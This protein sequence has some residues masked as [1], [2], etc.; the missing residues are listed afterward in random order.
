MNISLIGVF[1]AFFT[2]FLGFLLEGL[3]FSL[4][5]Q[6]TAMLIV[7]GGTLGA[8]MMQ[9]KKEDI[10]HLKELLKLMKQNHAKELDYLAQS[11]K[12]ATKI[13]QHKDFREFETYISSLKNKTDLEK[14]LLMVVDR[15]DPEIIKTTLESKISLKIHGY[16]RAVKAVESAAAYAPTIGILGSV[17][18]LLQVMSTI[19][20]PTAVA[21]GIAIC[22]VA[23]FYGLAFANLVLMPIANKMKV[24]V[25]DYQI[26]Q[27][28]ILETVCFM[29]A[30]KPY[31]ATNE[32]INSYS[33]SKK[34]A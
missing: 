4:L 11:L 32:N 24:V 23:T 2:V 16:K 3:S 20:D 18:G 33:D 15:I 21:S 8:A 27:Q 6:P 14:P 17:V 31:R 22:F 1:V 7:F 28:L 26:R 12:T 30:K 19:K 25:Q 5:L 13:S 34:A 29:A 10:D 9:M